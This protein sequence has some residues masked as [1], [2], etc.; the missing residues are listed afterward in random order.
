MSGDNE[1]TQIGK[2]IQ[3]KGEITGSASIEVWGEVEGTAGTEGLFR[4]REGGKV[5]GEVAAKNV[6]VD[7]EVDGQITAEQKI[8][9]SATCKV[10]GDIAARNVAV[11]DGAFFE[12]RVKMANR[13]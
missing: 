9:L 7:G 10:H 5:N 1:T 3:I 13:K 2:G 6:V 12:G 8:E 11:A 4:V